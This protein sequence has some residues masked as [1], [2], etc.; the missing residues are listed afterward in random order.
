[1]QHVENAPDDNPDDLSSGRSLLQPIG[2]VSWCIIE[3]QRN[4][5]KWFA[6]LAAAQIPLDV[7]KN[8]RA[9]EFCAVPQPGGQH[10][11]TVGTGRRF[12][13]WKPGPLC[14]E[15]PSTIELEEDLSMDLSPRHGSVHDKTMIHQKLI[16]CRN[17]SL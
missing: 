9:K 13:G 6:A 17:W 3:M 8:R 5:S 14:S 12:Q 16:P 11:K 7:S 2:I 15:F 1:V 4:G 10:K